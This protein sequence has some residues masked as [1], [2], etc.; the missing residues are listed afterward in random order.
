MNEKQLVRREPFKNFLNL[1]DDFGHLFESFFGRMPM[2]RQDLWLPIVDIIENNGNIEVKAE[3]PGMNKD[4]IKVRIKNNMLQLSGERKQEKEIKEKTFHRVERYFG[5]FCRTIQLPADINTDKIKAQY[6]DGV[7][8][9][10]LP[11]PESMK[12]KE[13][14][15][16]VK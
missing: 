8:N 5:K 15:V 1:R 10:T 14:E 9:I 6:K 4:D 16:E 11:K 12:P 7:L 2:E 3:L 13:I